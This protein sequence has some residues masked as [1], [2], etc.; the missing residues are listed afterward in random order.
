L[1]L[2]VP[3]LA[4]SIAQRLL[5]GLRGPLSRLD[6]DLVADN[7]ELE[8]VLGIGPRGFAPDAATWLPVAGDGGARR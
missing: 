7:G 2:P 5:P 6:R 4:T 8:R 1:P 3:R